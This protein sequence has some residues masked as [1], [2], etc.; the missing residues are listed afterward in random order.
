[1]TNFSEKSTFSFVAIVTLLLKTTS[2]AAL[3]VKFENIGEDYVCVLT[4]QTFRLEDTKLNIY[5]SHLKKSFN[6]GNVVRF[7]NGDVKVL[8]ASYKNNTLEQFPSAVLPLFPNLMEMR[9]EAI[10]L[11]VLDKNSFH[12]CSKVETILFGEDHIQS[13]YAAVFEKCENILVLQFIDN[14]IDQIDDAAFRGLSSLKVLNLIGNGLSYITPELLSPLKKLTTLTISAN[15]ISKFHPDT[16]LEMSDLKSLNLASNE[17]ITVSNLWFRNKNYLESVDLS[18]NFIAT[19]SRSLLENWP[20][21]A[22]LSLLSNQCIDKRFGRLGTDDLLMSD[23]IPYFANCFK[24]HDEVLKVKE[25]E[26]SKEY[27]ANREKSDDN[28]KNILSEVSESEEE[29]SFLGSAGDD[30][31]KDEDESENMKSSYD[32]VAD[33]VE[34]TSDEKSNEEGDS[35]RNDATGFLHDSIGIESEEQGSANKTNDVDDGDKFGEVDS[36]G[37]AI[38]KTSR[39]ES[40]D[41]QISS[42][43]ANTSH[44]DSAN[45]SFVETSA[46]NESIFDERASDFV[47]STEF[48]SESVENTTTRPSIQS[49]STKKSY[50]HT[51][52]QA[53]CRFYVNADEKYICVI[54]NAK[55]TLKHININ[56]LEGYANKD[57]SIVY[58]RMSNLLHIPRVVF[59]EFPNVVMLSLENCGIKVMDSGL[60]EICNNL[61]FLNLRYN[62]IHRIKG[63][64]LKMCPMLETVDLTG[65]PYE[66]IESSIFECNPKLNIT[67]G[68]L[69]IVS[70]PKVS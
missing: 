13:I 19:I 11:K 62:Q 16:F 68:P 39:V 9:L 5:G 56:H 49:T 7:K 64:S 38:N 36:E 65:N 35:N 25:I 15:S 57:V 52:E 61:Q 58:F 21:N 43:A 23:I 45:Q 31:F 29:T 55:N 51:Y 34:N 47:T 37:N 40:D 33:S 32:S 24:E 26:N 59:D 53:T 41:M 46:F 3:T 63:D 20:N 66:Y 27:S 17:L 69:K 50:H 18:S 60:L 54:N 22:A 1:M 67:L 10:N 42:Q 30:S 6:N 70:T 4:N 2:L 48:F 44:Q 28:D 8:D 14:V 12:N